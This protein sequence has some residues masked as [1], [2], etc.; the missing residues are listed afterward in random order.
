M[1]RKKKNATTRRVDTLVYPYKGRSCVC[2]LYFRCVGPQERPKWESSEDR[3]NVPIGVFSVRNEQ[4]S[5]R[6][7][8]RVNLI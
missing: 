3:S 8:V 2:T 7:L 1:G 6:H 4:Y 5:D